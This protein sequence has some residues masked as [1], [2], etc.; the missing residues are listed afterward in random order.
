MGGGG[1]GKVISRIN[2]RRLLQEGIKLAPHLVFV[3]YGFWDFVLGASRYDVR[4]RGR[5]G[6][7]EKGT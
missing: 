7:M 5:R 4:T 2:I 6:I 3:L 1:D